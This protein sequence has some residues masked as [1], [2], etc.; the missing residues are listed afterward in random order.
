[1]EGWRDRL[2]KE[3]SVPYGG[4]STERWLFRIPEVGFLGRRGED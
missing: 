3:S 2:G 1:M 4:K